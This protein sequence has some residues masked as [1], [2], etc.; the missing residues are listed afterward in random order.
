VR[1]T[2]Y[3]DCHQLDPEST[4]VGRLHNPSLFGGEDITLE[5]Y[6]LGGLE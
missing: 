5:P 6:R 4:F 3:Y 1:Q 2:L